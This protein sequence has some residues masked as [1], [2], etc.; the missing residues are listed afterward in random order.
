VQKSS[1]MRIIRLNP[2]AI[3]QGVRLCRTLQQCLVLA[4]S[5]SE[6]P[7]IGSQAPEAL[8][9]RVPSDFLRASSITAQMQQGC[10]AECRGGGRG[11]DGVQ[12]SNDAR[13]HD[14]GCSERWHQARVGGHTP[15]CKQ[16]CVCMCARAIAGLSSICRHCF[17][18]NTS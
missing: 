9:A 7:R 6:A 10:N 17:P 14:P 5:S 15:Y 4:C 16:H 2:R 3:H 8:Q 11:V 13:I 1:C 18:V 12:H